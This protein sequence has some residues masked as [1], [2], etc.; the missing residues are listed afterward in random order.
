M[1]VQTILAVVVLVVLAALVTGKPFYQA[2]RAQCKVGT[3]WPGEDGCNTC[4]CRGDS[5]SFACTTLSC[6][7][8]Q[9][10]I[11]NDVPVQGD[12][13]DELQALQALAETSTDHGQWLPFDISDFEWS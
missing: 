6:D 12:S 5:V 13:Q 9:A 11:D 3:S 1:R 4:T 10:R 8:V 7:P 2:R